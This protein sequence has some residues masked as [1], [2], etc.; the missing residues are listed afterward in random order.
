M[1]VLKTGLKD[2]VFIE[3]KMFGDEKGSF[4]ETFQVATCTDLAGIT[5]PFFQHNHLRSSKGVLHG[6]HYQKTKPQG[7]QARVVKDRVFDVAIDIRRG[8]DAYGQ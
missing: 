5:F 7:K 6:L 4:L 2:Y 3:P 8:T 1:N